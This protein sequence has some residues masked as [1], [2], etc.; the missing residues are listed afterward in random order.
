M[1]HYSISADGKRV[2]F[3]AVDDSGSTPVWVA[4]LNGQTP[5]RQLSTINGGAAFFGAAGEVIFGSQQTDNVFIYRI[6]DDG[7]E[8]R[9]MIPTPM[10]IPFGVSPDGRWVPAQT[11][12]QYGDAMIYSAGN[13]S[14]TRICRDCSQPQGTEIIPPPISWTPDGKFVYLKFKNSTY[15]IPLQPGQMLPPL[16][17]NGFPSKEAVAALPGARLVSEESMFPGPDPSIYAFTKVTTQRN[18]YRVPVQ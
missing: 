3:C 16:P 1:Q 4:S 11:P 15:A 10:L 7:T 9:K 12:N 5:P 13:G 6:K 2:V 8:L 14:P 18:I 17:A